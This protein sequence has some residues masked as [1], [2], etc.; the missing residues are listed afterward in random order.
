LNEFR[1]NI[2]ELRK[3]C[4]EEMKSNGIEYG[5]NALMETLGRCFPGNA[6]LKG[7]SLAKLV[8]KLNY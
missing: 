3:R 5:Q 8:C 6:E 7:I 4:L 2:Q 1:E